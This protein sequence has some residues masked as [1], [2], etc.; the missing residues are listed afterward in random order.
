M[1]AGTLDDR[2][3]N[4]LYGQISDAKIRKGSKTYWNLL[5][6]MHSTEFQ[7]FFPN[8]E[9]R[10]ADGKELRVQWAYEAHEVPE[11]EWLTL[12]CSFLEL[13][14]GLAKRM[15]FQAEMTQEYWFW[16]LLK[17]LDFDGF[18]DK[19]GY[20]S[21]F[22][23]RRIGVVNDRSYDAM[24]NGGLFPLRNSKDDQTQVD[25]WYQMMAYI[26]QDM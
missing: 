8:D 20:S 5:R 18:H 19:S 17:N 21:D 6:Q 9:N 10:A 1:P 15:T 11:V 16:Q 26:V 13:L 3:L 4:W 12:P 14:L 25:L 2:Y 7:D 22:V 23:A 24:G